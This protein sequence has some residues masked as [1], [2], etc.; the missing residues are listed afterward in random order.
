MLRHDRIR[1]MMACVL[2]MALW[3]GCGD[4]DN[5]DGNQNNNQN[6]NQNNNQNGLCG[7]DVID[8]GEMCDGST[9]PEPSCAA[10][11]DGYDQG[12]VSCTG[13]CTLDLTG[14]STCG[15]SVVE[16][17]EPCDDGDATDFDGCRVCEITEFLVT[18]GTDPLQDLAIPRLTTAGEIVYAY[19]ATDASGNDSIVWA[20]LDA[21]GFQVAGP[22]IVAQDDPAQGIDLDSLAFDSNDSGASVFAWYETRDATR[23][24]LVQRFSPTG[25]PLDAI[26]D[27]VATYSATM[28]TNYLGASMNA[29]GTYVVAHTRKDP[30]DASS[31]IA[32]QRFDNTGAPLGASVEM[33]HFTGSFNSMD[34]GI[35]DT[36][37]VVAVWYA[38]AHITQAGMYL[39]QV[40]S[41]GLFVSDRTLVATRL[42]NTGHRFADLDVAGDGRAVVAWITSSS[43]NPFDDSFDFQR[44]DASSMAVGPVIVA[45]AYTDRF[46]YTGEVKLTGDGGFVAIWSSVDASYLESP[47]HVRRF[48]GGGLDLWETEDIRRRQEE[49]S[50][51]MLGVA[52]DGRFVV[53][54][55][56]VN[57]DDGS[58][59]C[60]AQRFT[61][62]GEML[63]HLPW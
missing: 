13:Q 29:N 49:V 59:A 45:G 42:P 40:D 15:D 30:A 50:I 56:A 28:V 37:Q 21:L 3:S 20:K 32:V 8:D 9:I 61:A 44:F 24:V 1:E 35:G 48:D 51:P 2:A 26:P 5:Q 57:F 41:Q 10:L 63:G 16:G 39:R 6:S 33:D 46:I 34:V 43:E 38:D 55:G 47:I 25:T 23:L 12:Q 4:D 14:C 17:P 53:F 31:F 58:I 7:D 54:Y 19:N 62:S 11:G 18:D 22:V 52:S 36:G 27:V 60:Y